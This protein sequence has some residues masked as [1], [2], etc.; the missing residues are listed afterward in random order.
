[1]KVNKSIVV[2]AIAIV[3]YVKYTK[4]I[5][6]IDNLKLGLQVLEVE[7][8]YAVALIS[9]KNTR[10]IPYY[11][12][13]V[14]LML[15]KNVHAA[16][17]TEESTNLSVVPFSKIPINFRLLENLTIEELQQTEIAVKYKFYGFEFQ[18]LYTPEVIVSEGNPVENTTKK[19]GCQH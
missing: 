12:S 16:T 3:G 5:D 15:N 17:N 6:F 10:H 19:C 1:M 7:N 8:G 4:F 11:F 13:S 9:N 18:R 14:D 2:A